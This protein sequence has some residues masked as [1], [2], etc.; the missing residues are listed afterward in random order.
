MGT[1]YNMET[2]LCYIMAPKEGIP[3]EAEEQWTWKDWIPRN[4]KYLESE[5]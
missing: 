4:G 1:R 5:Q 3:A 2:Q